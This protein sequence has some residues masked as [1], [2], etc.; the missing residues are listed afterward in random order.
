MVLNLARKWRSRQFETVIGQH[1]P[2]RML[3]NSLYAQQFFPVYLFAG[4][5]GCGKTTT[6]RIFAAA[7]NCAQH[8]N[9]CKEPTKYVIPCLS[10][11][12]CT[13][14]ANGNHP[15]F[16]EIDAASHTGVDNVRAII[17]A[18]SLLP[19]LGTKKIYLIDEAHM[20]SKAAF[21]AL[22]KILEEPPV[23]VLFLLATTE[24]SKIID[25]VR[26]R[27]FQLFF[28]PIAID[29][30]TQH[31][32]YVCQQENIAINPEALTLIAR[33]S[34]GSARDALNIVERIRFADKGSTLATIQEILGFIDDTIVLQLLLA[35]FT[36]NHDA[37]TRTLTILCSSTPSVALWKKIIECLRGLIWFH[38]GH[39]LPEL[40]AYQT[41]LQELKSHTTMPKI[42]TM[43][44]LFYTHEQSFVR[45]TQ[46]SILLETLLLKLLFDVPEKPQISAAPQRRIS[47]QPTAVLGGT[48]NTPV[49]TIA[50][51]Y[52][53]KPLP[54][55]TTQNLNQ[56]VDT[57]LIPNDATPT[58]Q[59]ASKQDH[60]SEPWHH[61]LDSIE[62]LKDPLISSIFKQATVEPLTATGHVQITFPQQLVFF[63]DWLE[64]SRN[65]WE[66]I[67]HKVIGNHAKLLW[68]F[69]QAIAIKETKV[70][71]SPESPAPEI[72]KPS[73]SAPQQPKPQPAPTRF[74]ANPYGKTTKRYLSESRVQP[75]GPQAKL[76]LKVFSGTLTI[77][78]QQYTPPSLLNKEQEPT[79]E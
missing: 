40:A 23:S 4:L 79:H 63:N 37:V 55:A 16:I 32:A 2:I 8:A 76:L 36:K 53:P 33:A 72:I 70:F 15:D 61:F 39:I 30:L 49:Q 47:E 42:I 3:K 22:L 50:P 52:A 20:L 12:S 78:Q 73:E 77:V 9:F 65:L 34:E 46:P 14:F 27:C 64:K 31:L 48:K 5:R 28:K 43:L 56:A 45:T 26:S 51:T 57:T 18:A 24:S 1:L 17:E 60:Q 68:S 38:Q 11:H 25:T 7:V 54:L 35:V 13:A 67:L 29:E 44:E 75:Q 74:N 41:E 62:S 66:P 21:N 10:C 59:Y 19:V 6:A 58:D 71:T 69:N